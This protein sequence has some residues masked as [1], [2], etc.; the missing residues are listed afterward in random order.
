MRCCA[1]GPDWHPPQMAA[2][3][4]V[5]PHCHQHAVL[6]YT[7]ERHLLD[8]AGVRRTFSTPDV[9][10]WPATSVS[11]RATTTCPSHVPKT[12]CFRPSATPIPDKLILADGFSC[13]TQI[14]Q[15]APG[16]RPVHIAQLLAATH[17]R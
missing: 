3:A 13:R 10:G 4:L 5:Q 14:R 7:E 15:L 16:R 1:Q 9:A 6:R 8:D 2:S 11:R 12:N 17:Q